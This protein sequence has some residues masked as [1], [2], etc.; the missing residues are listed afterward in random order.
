[1]F[2]GPVRAELILALATL[3]RAQA[4][5][6]SCEW[7]SLTTAQL[8][9]RLRHLLSSYGWLSLDDEHR[10]LRRIIEACRALPSPSL[11]DLARAVSL[12][13]P[14]E[15]DRRAHPLFE[16][17]GV[18]G[19]A[20]WRH[21]KER[22]LAASCAD[23]IK[24]WLEEVD[25]QE[26][27]RTLPSV[28]P[29]DPPQPL[30]DVHIDVYAVSKPSGQSAGLAE[31]STDA[32]NR[33]RRRTAQPLLPI[34]N[35]LSRTHGRIIIV[36]DPGSGKST[37]VNWLTRVINR[38][39]LP[40]FDLAIALDLWEY[41]LQAEQS[42]RTPFAHFFARYLE[43]G[44][45]AEAAANWFRDDGFAALRPVLLLDGL[46]E[47][48]PRSRD[49]VRRLILRESRYCKVI[50]TSRPSVGA[51]AM[52][53]ESSTPLYELAGLSLKA[54]D[55]LIKKRLQCCGMAHKSRM[56]IEI[57]RTDDVLQEISTNPFLLTLLTAAAAIEEPAELT[58]VASS[59]GGL[60][61]YFV[62]WME[63]H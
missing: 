52:R 50:V 7:S 5:P 26:R 60:Y 55:E 21:I 44:V 48:P 34:A 49:K 53:E 23:A 56:L 29:D 27:W 25:S 28:L 51:A 12:P 32:R 20:A 54:R 11:R 61:R 57:I 3:A 63:E 9:V 43:P 4:Y 19:K 16:K 41:S 1:M 45:D 40:D 39:V 10:D 36:G 24:K 59:R 22:A 30:D 58:R 17:V 31:A 18:F 2:P 37:L 15:E 14:A 35:V 8:L 6:V 62:R 42:D 47:V 33:V 46:D 13:A 38:G